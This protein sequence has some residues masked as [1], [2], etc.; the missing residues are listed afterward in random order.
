V[1]AVILAGGRGSRL[2]EETDSRPK[3]LVEIGGR[4]II[5]HIMNIYAHHGIDEFVVCTGYRGYQFKEYF[6]NLSLHDADVTFDLEAGS[7]EFHGASS[8]RWKVTVADTG[9][10]TMTAGRVRRIVPYLTP[11][12]TFCLTYGDGVADV[13]I[14]DVIRFH[15]EQGRLVTMTAVA[16]PARFGMLQL[17]GSL[18]TAMFEKRPTR[19]API[20]GGYFVVEPEALEL[21][22]GDADRWE[23][24]VLVPLAERGQ[25]AAYEHHG[26]WQPMDTL[27]EKDILE[28][29][30]RSGE[31][32]WKVWE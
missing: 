4:P 23:T 19:I 3:P 22:H 25:L 30:W 11:G 9:P 10:E 26:F 8:V 16:P 32:P 2:A 12:E 29:L 1:R 6:A 14:S 15:R 28:E 20:N 13:D 18:V 27:W 7:V 31:A 21:I 5:W 17:D 24:D